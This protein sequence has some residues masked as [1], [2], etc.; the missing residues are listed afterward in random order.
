[1]TVARVLPLL[2]VPQ[3][4]RLFD[5]AIPEEL[6]ELAQP[7]VRVRVRFHGRRLIGIIYE[8]TDTTD[9]LGT[10]TPIDAV[11]AADEVLPER[12]RHLVDTLAHRYGSTRADIVR[13]ALPPRHTAA[14]KADTTTSWDSLG[15]VEEPDLSEWAAY[16]FGP[17][18]VDAVLA[19]RAPRAAWQFL[20]FQRWVEALAALA[21]KVA[22]DGGGVLIIA[23]TAREVSRVDQALRTHVAATQVTTLEAQLG[24]QA[25]YRRYL[26]IVHGQGRIV[27]GTRGAVYA[28]VVNLQL[29]VCLF[30]SDDSMKETRQPY[31]HARDVAAVRAGAESAALIIGGYA[32]SAETQQ[33]V[34][35]GWMNSLSPTEQALERTRPA[36]TAATGG[37]IPPAAYQAMYETLRAGDSVLV[38][39]P[40]TGYS[41]VVACTQ[42]GTPP[43]CRHCNG[44]L[45]ITSDQPNYPTCRWCGRPDANHHCEVCGAT[46]LRAVL[47][48][49]DHTAEELG[50]AFPGT[51]V[52]NSSGERIV[53]AITPGKHLV[54]ATPGAEPTVEGGYGLVVLVDTWTFLNDADV[55]A[56]EH[57]L[58][59]WM[60]AASRAGA[61]KPVIIAADP[62]LPTVSALLAWDSV[63]AA[64]AE[65]AARR[66]VG[67]P[68][69]VVFV[70]LDGSAA[71]ITDFL[72]SV[73]LPAE[74]EVLGPVEMPTWERPPADYDQFRDG[75][76]QRV[77][78][79]APLGSR[80][81]LMDRLRA[82]RAT[83]I[84]RRQLEPL[85]VQVD[86]RRIG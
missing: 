59:A 39:V 36:L 4:D 76:A 53:D 2:Q 5:Y 50:R 23:P 26:S 81:L 9:F 49:T 64:A 37:R 6:S 13:L 40:R 68:P 19:H 67:F 77:L 79:R 54:I 32:R 28:P 24:P 72:T 78:L 69:A 61:G 47:K 42:C 7:G 12:S 55:R 70:A 14:E 35:S 3:V 17:S 25:R 11:V 8:L 56:H 16:R 65:L 10:L 73:D 22:M 20:P 18:F 63:G 46:G 85:R 34:E 51:A 71:T 82:A 74:V 83:R 86:P 80:T 38:Q 84:A 52:T 48:G 57:A 30:D 27:V 41:P 66:E 21:A 45:H 15:A 60:N 75:P 44:P 33:L 29:V 62:S 43:R 58:A 31:C 1:M